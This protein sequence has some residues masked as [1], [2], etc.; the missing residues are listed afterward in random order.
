MTLACFLCRGSGRYRRPELHI[1]PAND[2]D[3]CPGCQGWGRVPARDCPA[4]SG[5]GRFRNGR[6]CPCCAGAGRQPALADLNGDGE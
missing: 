2:A 3:P 5:R 1:F 6:D 4:C